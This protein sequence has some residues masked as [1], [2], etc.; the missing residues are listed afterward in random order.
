[1]TAVA[2]V[3]SARRSHAGMCAVRFGG[4]VMATARHGGLCG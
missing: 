2:P 4:T 1:M 3:T